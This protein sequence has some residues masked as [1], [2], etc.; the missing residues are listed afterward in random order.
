M[1]FETYFIFH[2]KVK[3]LIICMSSPLYFKLVVPCLVASTCIIADC[4]LE[5]DSINCYLVLLNVTIDLNIYVCNGYCRR[6]E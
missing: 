2:I 4:Y 6:N 3:L 5:S 1:H